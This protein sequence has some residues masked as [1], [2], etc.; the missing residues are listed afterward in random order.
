MRND[1]DYMHVSIRYGVSSK[2][3][4]SSHV[5]ECVCIEDPFKGIFSVDEQSWLVDSPCNSGFRARLREC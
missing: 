4:T 2:G 3:T 1:V 5:F